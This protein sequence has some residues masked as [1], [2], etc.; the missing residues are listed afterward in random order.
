MKFDKEI[1]IDNKF[2]GTDYPT[3]IIAE[4][5][6]N[7]VG[8]IGLAKELIDLAKDAGADAVKFQAFR[9]SELIIENVG[10]A[11]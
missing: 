1:I 5:G 3:F 11:P 6:V 7:H 4:A 8:D 2:I 9:T 10:K